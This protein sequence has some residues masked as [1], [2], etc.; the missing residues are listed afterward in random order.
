MIAKSQKV[1][2]VTVQIP[3]PSRSVTEMYL[4]TE[5]IGVEIKVYY[6]ARR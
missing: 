6:N 3:D 1:T 4:N 5:N 2:V